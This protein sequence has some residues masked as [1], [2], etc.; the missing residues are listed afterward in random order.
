MSTPTEG[1]NL[2]MWIRTIFYMPIGILTFLEGFWLLI[3]SALIISFKRR[4]YWFFVSCSISILLFILISGCVT[5]ITRTGTYV[6]PVTFIALK[7]INDKVAK[8][9]I[10]T[11]LLVSFVFSFLIPPIVVCPDW[12]IDFWFSNS[13]FDLLKK[14]L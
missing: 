13:N 10:R 2:L 4:D 12:S 1:A 5:D 14:I 11:L 7:Y 6:F 9:E 3:I 8:F